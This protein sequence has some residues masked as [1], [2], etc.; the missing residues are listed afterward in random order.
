MKNRTDLVSVYVGSILET[1]VIT[2]ILKDNNI[3]VLSTERFQEGLH[4]GFIDGVPGDVELMVGE[5]NEER[6]KSLIQEF[7]DA[8]VQ[9]IDA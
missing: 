4:A 3:P 6:A 9:N 8:A 2:E 7:K 1:N 5:E